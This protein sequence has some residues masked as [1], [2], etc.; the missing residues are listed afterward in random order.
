MN[1]FMRLSA[2]A[3]EGKVWALRIEV[4]ISLFLYV[5]GYSLERKMTKS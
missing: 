4:P 2:A 1:I 3:S 5:N